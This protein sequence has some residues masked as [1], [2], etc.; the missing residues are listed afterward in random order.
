MARRGVSATATA[1]ATALGLMLLIGLLLITAT[2]GVEATPTPS[3]DGDATTTP[4]SLSAFEF[5]T[6]QVTAQDGTTMTEYALEADAA[7]RLANDA[8]DVFLGRRD[9]AP[10]NCPTALASSDPFCIINDYFAS[11]STGYIGTTPGPCPTYADG[12]CEAWLCQ[13]PSVF[14]SQR[15]TVLGITKDLCASGGDLFQDY[16][17]MQ[18]DDCV[19]WPGKVNIFKLSVGALSVKNIVLTLANTYTTTPRYGWAPATCPP[20]VNPDLC[21]AFPAV[22]PNTMM[23]VFKV[24]G[25]KFD[26]ELLIKTRKL[27]TARLLF[28][29]RREITL[30]DAFGG[31]PVSVFKAF[32]FNGVQF[33][34]VMYFTSNLD[35]DATYTNPFTGVTGECIS[36]PSFVYPSQ[37]GYP[38]RRTE[39]FA[40]GVVWRFNFPTVA[41][42]PQQE[43][44][45]TDLACQW[46]VDGV[47]SDFGIAL[48]VAYDLFPD[49]RWCL[50]CL[51]VIDL[52]AII[53]ANVLIRSIICDYY[54]LLAYQV[55]G[56]HVINYNAPGP[57]NN[58]LQ[59]LY[60]KLRGQ[61]NQGL[62]SSASSDL[63][64]DV[65]VPNTF[66]AAGW[67]QSSWPWKAPGYRPFVGA[68]D[69][70]A[71]QTF[72]A[73][74]LGINGILG[75]PSSTPGY[76]NKLTV[77]EVI[78]IL[79]GTT[80][81]TVPLGMCQGYTNPGCTL[82]YCPGPC[83]NGIKDQLM[84]DD[85]PHFQWGDDYYL[86]RTSAPSAGG[87]PDTWYPYKYHNPIGAGGNPMFNGRI[88]L[89]GLQLK[90]L[91]TI[92]RFNFLDN[93]FQDGKPRHTHIL[94]N[95]FAMDKLEV[96]SSVSLMLTDGYWM[97]RNFLINIKLNGLFIDAFWPGA[98]NFN[99][100]RPLFTGSMSFDFT[101][102]V[103]LSNIAVDVDLM[104][105]LMPCLLYTSDAAD[106]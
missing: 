41:V 24:T 105:L 9:L 106:D 65:T 76:E 78:D 30:G 55:T 83:Q 52:V 102:D 62:T 82:G 18:C 57:L 73:V 70:N 34:T 31:N 3:E 69:F 74:S 53:L 59:T 48:S 2:G 25:I 33:Q 42:G 27:R 8:A 86:P 11:P 4:L 23:V 63:A 72:K 104:M 103:V 7:T 54:V 10:S 68:V 51:G 46:T 60:D 26:M 93:G 36:R 97:H 1:T 28:D 96:K 6:R 85:Y 58:A 87:T 44:Y 67:P 75:R 90:Y 50:L 100:Y 21:G 40:T 12:K 81:G 66:F 49:L 13:M 19:N 99:P 38:G 20:T 88:Q 95:S 79:T 17:W 101:L 92:T 64:E 47:D 84:L 22:T 77:V 37:V 39:T 43:K 56:D 5:K 45:N 80:D 89:N 32:Q 91:N 35:C 16:G 29:I 94:E 15:V 61:V 71:S 14:K 98:A